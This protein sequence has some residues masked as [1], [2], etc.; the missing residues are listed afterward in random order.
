M[1]RKK[2]AGEKR[3]EGYMSRLNK[4]FQKSEETLDASIASPEA[5]DQDEM[6]MAAARSAEPFATEE[7]VG[8]ELPAETNADTASLVAE[9]NTIAAEVPNRAG[10]VELD[11]DFDIDDG[12]DTFDTAESAPVSIPAPAQVPVPAPAWAVQNGFEQIRATESKA[13]GETDSA[14]VPIAAAIAAPIASPIDDNDGSNSLTFEDIF[15]GDDE[16]IAISSGISGGTGEPEISPAMAS[17]EAI[18]GGGTGVD[19][20]TDDVSISTDDENSN[21]EAVNPLESIPFSTDDGQEDTAM[22]MDGTVEPGADTDEAAPGEVLSDDPDFAGMTVEQEHE[23][24]EV[25]EIDMSSA[26]EDG[27][28]IDSDEPVE[29]PETIAISE[30]LAAF[31]A[32]DPEIADLLSL[33]DSA[34]GELAE[35]DTSK[36]AE[37][38]D[39]LGTVEQEGREGDGTANSTRAGIAAERD[40]QIGSEDFFSQ[41]GGQEETYSVIDGAEI[42]NS[43]DVTGNKAQTDEGVEIPAEIAALFTSQRRRYEKSPKPADIRN[44]FKSKMEELDAELSR[45][46][47]DSKKLDDI[48][49]DEEEQLLDLEYREA[50]EPKLPDT[51]VAVL[52]DDEYT[53]VDL[54]SEKDTEDPFMMEDIEMEASWTNRDFTVWKDPETDDTNDETDTVPVMEETSDDKQRT[55]GKM[56]T[57]GIATDGDAAIDA[58]VSALTNAVSAVEYSEEDAKEQTEEYKY[59][60]NDEAIFITVADYA[61]TEKIGGHDH[62]EKPLEDNSRYVADDGGRTEEEEREF[63]RNINDELGDELV[64]I[65]DEPIISAEIVNPQS[66]LRDDIGDSDI[67]MESPEYGDDNGGENATIGKNDIKYAKIK[68]IYDRDKKEIKLDDCMAFRERY[69]KIGKV[70]GIG[71]DCFFT[72]SISGATDSIGEVEKIMWRLH[73]KDGKENIYYH[74]EPDTIE[75]L[76]E[77]IYDDSY[78]IDNLMERMKLFITR[79]RSHTDE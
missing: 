20:Q 21:T 58:A 32:S 26:E 34:E 78:D 7:T 30:E 66:E 31:A 63:I 19:E 14:D 73:N 17:L 1:P 11:E 13:D 53:A 57:V 52:L 3:K 22:N 39:K 46:D 9:L 23:I 55:V 59:D 45:L 48:L 60:D 10:D 42:E 8:T 61:E 35:M 4:I 79:E 40:E 12:Y 15:G 29:E 64:Q 2:N 76:Q 18:L 77:L 37:L 75:N 43:T 68:A 28:F 5:I 69:R 38:L 71:D 36:F 24:E 65:I 70:I 54:F 49:L 50:D 56:E 41:A 44:K 51:N 16:E 72:L 74:Y 62:N 27:N 47:S 6:E 33:C 25:L 67:I